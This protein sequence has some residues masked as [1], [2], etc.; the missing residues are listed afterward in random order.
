M[1]NIFIDIF[2]D[3]F[4]KIDPLRLVEIADQT[5]DAKNVLVVAFG[6]V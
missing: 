6:Y 4:F 3:Q 1:K 2:Y 5:I